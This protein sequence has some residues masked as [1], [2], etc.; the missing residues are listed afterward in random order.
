MNIVNELNSRFLTQSLASKDGGLSAAEL[1]KYKKIASGYA[2]MENA[3]AVL[4]DMHANVSYVYY[5]QFS[6]TLGWRCI[7]AAENRIDSIWEDGILK[8]MH[9]DDLHE[10]YLQE[11]RFFHFV[12]RQPKMKRADFYLA[13]KLRMKDGAGNYQFVLH[14]LFYVS[15]P[16]TNGLWLALCVYT[17]WFPMFAGKSVVVNSVTGEVMELGRRNDSQILSYRETQILR[18]IAKGMMSK[19]IALL[20]SISINTVSRHRQEIL[21]KLQVKSSIEACRVARELGII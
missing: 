17:P 6:K 18:L 1:D 12:R 21:R 3:V 2:E 10:K 5:G 9:P 15:S 19:D 8:L 4:S 13:S 16:V 11:L 20:L 14:R 7:P